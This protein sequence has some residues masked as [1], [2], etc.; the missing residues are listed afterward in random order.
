M[1]NKKRVSWVVGYPVRIKT[2]Q[3]VTRLSGWPVKIAVTSYKMQGAIQK[4][5]F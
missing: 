2:G 1:C 5:C 4:A 3:P